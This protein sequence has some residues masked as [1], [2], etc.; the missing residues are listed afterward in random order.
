MK[1]KLLFTTLL[2]F[3]IITINAAPFKN[4]EKILTQ[5]DGTELHCYASGDEFYSRLHDKDGYTI[6]QAENG[7]FVY[8]T[9]NSQG[10]IIATQHIAGK[11]DPKALGLVPNIKISQ[12]EYL[13]KRDRMRVTPQRN[14]IGLNHGAYN[15]IVVFIK[16]QGDDDF[17]TSKTQI[18]SMFN[19]D[20]YYDISMNNYF[21]K[22][23]YNQLSMKSYCYPKADGDKLMAY[24][25]MYSRNY[26]RPYNAVTNPDGYNEHNRGKREFALLKRAIE[27]IAEEIPDTLNIDRNEDGLVDNV[28]F[29]VKGNVGDWS[30]L[31]W[32]HMWQLHGEDVYIHNKRVMGFNFQLETSTYFTVSTLCH[33]MA[34]SLGFPDLYHYNQAYEYLSPT[35][36]WDL[37]CNNSQPPQHTATYMKYKYGTWIDDIPEIEYGT[38]T[39]EANSWEGGRRNCYKIP[40]SDTN[41]FYLVEYR[42]KN[43]IFEKGLPDGGLLIY[44]L[45]TRFNGCIEYNGNDILDELYI[46]RPNGSHNKNGQINM[47][48][49]SAD[50][51]KTEFNSTT[52]PYPFLNINEVDGDINICNISAKGDNMTFSYL[53]KNSSIIPTNLIANVNKDKY[54]ELIWDTVSMADSYN[55]YRD[56][57][58]IASDV[59]ENFY[60]DEYQN[61]EKGYHNYFVSS[62]CNREES[63]R[64]NKE[65]VIIGDY[66]EYIFDMNCTG[67]NGWQGGEITVSF[68]NG[69][70]DIFLT[71]YSGNNKKESIVVP[72]D[73]EMSLKWADS[74]DNTECSFTMSNND[75]EIYKSEALNE[76]LLISINTESKGS[77]IAPK[78]LTATV[79]EP[80]VN[81]K[82]NS[83]VDCDSYTI[84][85]NDKVIAEGITSNF[86]TD[87]TASGSGTLTYTVISNKDGLSSL[88]STPATATIM[89]YNRDII[90]IAA[91][92]ENGIVN[93]EWNVEPN[94]VSHSINY[95]DGKFVTSIGSS[96]NTWGIMIPTE[97]LSKY[98]GAKITAIEIFDATETNYSFNIYNGEKPDN[99][100]IHQESFKTTNSNEFVR[101]KL[102]KEVKFDANKNLW[103]TA[104]SAATS[105]P[106]IPCGEF[107]G[108]ENSNLI[109]AGASWKSATHYDMNYSWLIR[110]HIEQDDAFVNNLSYNIYREDS[111]IASNIKSTTYSYSE[112]NNIGDTICYNIGVTYNNND[113]IY[114]DKVCLTIDSTE[115]DPKPEPEPDE[116]KSPKLYPNPT[117]DYVTIID[118]N[119][120]KI[121]IYSISGTT[122]LEE[123]TK[124]NKVEIDMRKF[125]RGIYLIHVVTETETKTYKLVRN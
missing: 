26:Y 111:L 125:A 89:N 5:P 106:P 37:M 102:S 74:W 115:P 54:V 67:D 79:A 1:I 94:D 46:F 2:L 36:P 33:E 71:M 99:N 58:L 121:K 39:I 60:H 61:L 107:I 27:H 34:H 45:D 44:R 63:F 31:L 120:K 14:K 73:I 85:R 66:C 91:T 30:D 59:T 116:D 95:D 64:S 52:D 15:N 47:A 72:T 24:E 11:S 3:C 90:D 109:K 84:L 29:V 83:H 75:G 13:K 19:N 10:D 80:Y 56:G 78:N 70:E 119:I 93:L 124:G 118:D 57:T 17:K 12:E 86:Y 7:Y 77:C 49:F 9:T 42:N 20:G 32:P 87:K 38:Y 65:N 76:G 21:K 53:P 69:M 101:F 55:V 122:L 68:N 82:W 16:F 8:A 114:S 35:G 105:N 104:K 113:I 110:L 92:S 88:P 97:K 40:T 50:N 123:D 4:V 48:T 41:Q 117:K 23:T 81:L 96:S 18:D 43:N 62:N 28:I 25:D 108:L 112:E 6:V 103:L 98:K 51:N 100:P 22:A